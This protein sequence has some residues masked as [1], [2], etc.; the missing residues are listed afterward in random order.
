MS[1]LFVKVELSP[2]INHG[3]SRFTLWNQQMNSSSFL[4]HIGFIVLLIGLCFSSYPAYGQDEFDEPSE[5]VTKDSTREIMDLSRQ[6]DYPQAIRLARREVS[7]RVKNYGPEDPYVAKALQILATLHLK[8]GNTTKAGALLKRALTIRKNALGENHLEYAETLNSMGQLYYQLGNYKKVE[9]FYQRARQIR[10]KE[11]G[12]F[13]PQV[14]SV[15]NNLAELYRKTGNYSKAET[16][17][18]G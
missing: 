8:T 3:I 5:N 16:L 17:Y 10:I 6:G 9:S 11:L 18:P 7:K 2:M 12:K 15:Q 14:A 1:D 4:K 13:H